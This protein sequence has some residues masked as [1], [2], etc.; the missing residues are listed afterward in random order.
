[1]R[2]L[3]AALTAL[4]LAVAFLAPQPASAR[5]MENLRKPAAIVVD[6][7]TGNVLFEQ[8]A[9]EARYPASVTKVMTL[10]ILFQELSAGHVKLDTQF[11]VSKHAAAASP[12]KLGLRAGSKIKVEDVIKSIVTI[13]A[14]D[15]ARVVA[16]NISGSEEAFAKRMTATARAMGMRHTTYYN[17]SGLPD[18]RQR[19]TV[20][21]QAILAAA[22]YE[23]FPQY[24]HY[25]QTKSF[26]YGRRVYGNHDRILG[27]MGVDGLK[28]GYINAAG[29]NLMTATRQG[30]RHLVVIAFG[31]N[32]GGQRDARVRALVE[33]Y[34]PK[35]R[36]GK[37]LASAMIQMPSR[38]G[39]P[40]VMLA[41]VDPDQVAAPTIAGA[42]SVLP[43]PAPAFRQ[44]DPLPVAYAPEPMA[45]PDPPPG[46]AAASA[47]AV[48]PAAPMD[49]GVKPAVAAL[50]AIGE[51]TSS[52]RPAPR[53]DVIGQSL[54]RMLL[55]APPAALGQTR[56]SAPLVPPVGIGE[57][58]EPIDLMTSGSIKGHQVAEVAIKG[59]SR[60]VTSPSAPAGSWVVQIGAAPTQD[61]ASRLLATATG[62]IDA[63][64]DLRPYVERFDKNGQTFFRARFIGFGDEDAAAG[65]CKQLKKAKMSCLAMQS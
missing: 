40:T 7:K 56:P 21:D 39:K 20:R 64:N 11:T 2:G 52:R 9:D 17:A 54:S 60:V 43:L 42:G 61:G 32:T 18:G 63:L 36:Q 55:G 22:V 14:N 47:D 45:Y 8:H 38:Q 12:T 34:L 5:G 51:P 3:V 23:H 46:A 37:Y 44:D 41:N 26:A 65:M 27:F 28:T 4:V 6:A 33:K 50:S 53:P 59:D 16:E 31:Y 15:M 29:Y 57:G 49:I 13:S 35:A 1:V 10:Y 25:F 24:V 62:R 48:I 58:N 30:N 19:T